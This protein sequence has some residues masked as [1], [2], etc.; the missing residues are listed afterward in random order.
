VSYD[1]NLRRQTP[2]AQRLKARIAASGPLSVADY[3]AA[4]LWDEQTGYYAT[5]DVIGGAGDFITAAEISQ[6]FGELLGLWSGVVWQQ[7][8]G[9]PQRFTFAEFGPGRGTM[10]RDM[11]RATRVVPGFDNSVSV[12]LVEASLTLEKLQ[13]ETLNGVNV[14][15]SWGH[16]LASFPAP[17]I[18]VANEFLDAWPVDQWMRTNAGWQQR[19]VGL[20]ASGE[21]AFCL[22][23]GGDAS[24]ALDRMY[25]N[26]AP[27]TIVESQRPER[28]VDALRAVAHGGPLAALIIDYGY[29]SASAGGTLQA[30]REHA[31][32]HVLTS[33]GEADISAHVSFFELASVLHAAGFQI[34]GPTTQA[35]FLGALGIIE[36]ASR[37]MHGNPARAGEIEAGV[38]R[39]IA[40]Q[41][42]GTR[43]KV[44]GVR[45]AGL[46][47]LPGFAPAGS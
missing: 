9:A 37:L 1:P 26:A 15:V 28:F 38:A 14:P 31:Y 35:E 10:M 16:N 21:L 36:R 4:C 2:L 20:D 44:I 17:A 41:G 25:P 33:P 46:P 23:E 42:M 18:I 24:G 22:R 7:V 47:P 40:P 29:A 6:V 39:L 34:D 32:E 27:G 13:R 8:L 11:L 12:H 3:M 43:F 30:V 19:G 45:S 5:R